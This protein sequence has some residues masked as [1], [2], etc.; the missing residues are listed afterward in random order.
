M[1]TNDLITVRAAAEIIGV[2]PSRVRQYI[3]AGLL[4]AVS[5]TSRMQM[6]SERDAR[7]FR[8]PDGKRGPKTR[9]K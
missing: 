2:Q 8:R 9:E 7:R 5:I 6:V 4:P 3:R 1:K